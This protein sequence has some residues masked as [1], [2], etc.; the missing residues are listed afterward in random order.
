MYEARLAKLETQTKQVDDLEKKR[1][2]LKEKL[3]TIATLKIKKH[4]PVHVLDDLNNAIPEKAWI[5]ELRDKNG[6]LEI[7][8]VALDNQ[9]IAQFM[10]NLGNFGSFD[11]DKVDLVQSFEFQ[12][13]NVKLKQF[14]LAVALKDQL[15]LQQAAAAEAAKTAEE[16]KKKKKSKEKKSEV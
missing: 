4:G 2:L 9:T 12:Q 16:D 7:S 5:T 14:T 15:K 3:T 6:Q 11:R 13:D 8:G 10:A 1:N